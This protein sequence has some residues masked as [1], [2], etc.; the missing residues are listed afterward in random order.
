[1]V[2]ACR[3]DPPGPGVTSSPGPAPGHTGAPGSGGGTAA[4]ALASSGPQGADASP[5]EAGRAAST[6]SAPGSASD[7]IRT[8]RPL[9]G[10]WGDSFSATSDSGRSYTVVLATAHQP[11]PD[12][13]AVAYY[14]LALALGLTS[15]PPTVGRHVPLATVLGWLG[16]DSAARD[17]LLP[18]AVVSNDGTVTVLLQ[19]Q[20]P[21][22]EVLAAESPETARWARLA[23]SPAPLAASDAAAVRGYVEMALLDYLSGNVARRTLRLDGPSARICLLDQQQA[24]PGF[25]APK[26]WDVLLGRVRPVVRF[27]R[28]LGETL[29]HF[30]RATAEAALRS[31]AFDDWLLGPRDVVELVDRCAT[32][33]TLVNARIEQYG[34]EVDL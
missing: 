3:A 19:E 33:L 9:G 13:H 6:D 22:R 17:A 34:A 14:R 25:L 4:R 27:P 31:G 5:R 16:A 11:R 2:A 1:M 32:L 12:R 30:D 8:L 26:A 23:S 24:F 7:P 29:A 18:K 28:G 10:E 20:C 21:G 15:V